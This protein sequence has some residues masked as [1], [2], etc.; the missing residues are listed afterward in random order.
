MNYDE[1][2][3][4]GVSK[5]DGAVIGSG[6]YPLGSGENPYQ[7]TQSFY[8]WTRDLKQDGYS[9]K[10]ISD[11]AKEAGGNESVILRA[12]SKA[13]YNEE[14]IKTAMGIKTE[15]YRALMSIASENEKAERDALIWK[16]IN[17]DQMSDSAIA[18]KMG[19]APTTIHSI[20]ERSGEHEKQGN[21]AVANALKEALK[22]TEEGMLDVGKGTEEYIG[23]SRTRL[24]NALDILKE[25]GYNVYTDKAKQVFTGNKTTMLV[26]TEPDKTWKDMHYNLD[27]VGLPFEFYSL[28][29]GADIAKVKPPSSLDSKRV[30][31]RY[32]EEGGTDKDGVIELRRNVPDLSLGNSSYAQ[33][34]IKVDGTHYIKGMAVYADDR[35]LP[36][37]VDVL[38]NTNK[39]KGTPLL[40]SDP[41]AKQVL[42]PLKT[43]DP[44]STDPFGASLRPTGQ[45]EY[46]DKEGNLKLS[47]INKLNEEGKWGEWGK[48]LPAQFLSKQPKALAKEQLNIAY[49]D[50]RD[51]LKEIMTIT[52]PTIRQKL[53]EDFAGSCDTDSVTLKAAAMVGQRTHV[54][55]PVLSLKD[56]EV[57]APNY[58]NG[59]RLVLIRY[60]HAGKFEIPE[61]IV[62]NNNKEGQRVL[63]KQAID[64]IGVRPIVAAQLS[65]ADYDGDTVM[66][67]PNN[68]GRIKTEKMIASLSKFDNKAEFPY[69]E[70][71]KVMTKRDKGIEMGKITNLIQ[72]MT[73]FGAG[74]DEIVRAVKHSMV[75]I[76]AEKHK[77]D[78]KLS[79]KV[80]DI[81]SLKKKYQGRVNPETGRMTYA[82]NTLMT[83]ARNEARI[84]KRR[85]KY[86]SEMT[87]DELK[88]YKEGEQIFT[89]SGYTTSV[90]NKKT[91]EWETKLK[92]EK[93]PKMALTKDARTLV[94]NKQEDIE[95]IYADYANQMK[96]LANEARKYAR[97]TPRTEYSPAAARVYAKEVQELKDKKALAIRNQPKERRA[98]AY[99]QIKIKEAKENDPTLIDDDDKFKKVKANALAEGRAIY[100]A[101]HQAISFTPKQWEAIN[102]GAVSTTLFSE[103]IRHVDADS[104]K[105]MALPQT[106]TKRLS[107][108][109]KSIIKN[110]LAR[111][112]PD[113]TKAYSAADL[114]KKYG[115]SVSTIQSIAS[116]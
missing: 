38:V 53:L 70:G 95:L 49:Q 115:V 7:R 112:R 31:I 14:T 43:L 16:Y 33:V 24:K 107:P 96:T 52:N 102:A 85:E 13:G 47:P 2:Y 106:T 15:R 108:A 80:F 87:P 101:K 92:L 19:I 61:L 46:S 29:G 11:I 48:S 63:G 54:L 9:A 104:L 100:G 60:P 83:L 109:E 17:D 1:L 3:H 6:R 67:I 35:D 8:G 72:D 20:R 81:D 66:V 10:D 62:N 73:T 71:M 37:G 25:E 51:Q 21:I 76:D 64:A 88:R 44:N 28:D 12:L 27:K 116:M 79:E 110:L 23:V 103:I 78:Y 39:K 111:T 89:E 91:G 36:N 26:L 68:S 34:R 55:L 114:A 50:K 98:Q 69:R 84:P 32:A 40:S 105:K 93:V 75:V 97:A 18:K 74:Q 99:A 77:L 113:G 59:E 5:R 30:G 41:N 4:E 58:Q 86:V 22:K 42:K 45:Y 90:K 57:Y 94:S 65:G 82:P 56:N